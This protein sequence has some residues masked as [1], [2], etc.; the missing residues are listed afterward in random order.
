[1]DPNLALAVLI[2]ALALFNWW[3]TKTIAKRVA[4]VL[5]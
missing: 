4:L 1:M 5:R 3:H 2:I